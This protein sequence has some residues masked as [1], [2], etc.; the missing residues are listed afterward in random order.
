MAHNFLTDAM[1]NTRKQSKR[2]HRW[3]K[4]EVGRRAYLAAGYVDG[5]KHGRQQSKRPR[6]QDDDHR[7]AK[8]HHQRQQQ[9]EEDG[10]KF[11]LHADIIIKNSH[12]QYYVALP[13]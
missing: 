8:H 10:S 11:L 7:D 1:P 12:G 6:K 3:T 5:D 2:Q 4:D 13:G 9:R